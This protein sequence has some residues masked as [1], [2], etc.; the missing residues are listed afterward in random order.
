MS[1]FFNQFV[2][3]FMLVP[4]MAALIVLSF[5][6]PK[7]FLSEEM[8]AFLFMLTT[9]IIGIV[10]ARPGLLTPIRKKTPPKGPAVV[11]LPGPQIVRLRGTPQPGAP[12]YGRPV[13]LPVAGALAE[14]PAVKR[15]KALEAEAAERA[16]ARKPKVVKARRP[17]SL[18]EQAED[19]SPN[20]G[21]IWGLVILIP[22]FFFMT[23]IFAQLPVDQGNLPMNFYGVAILGSI[24]LGVAWAAVVPSAKQRKAE[25]ILRQ[26]EREKQTLAKKAAREK[27]QAQKDTITK[28][29][30]LE[31]QAKER[32]AKQTLAITQA[33]QAAAAAGVAGVS[34]AGGVAGAVGAAGAADA[35]TL[36][37]AEMGAGMV[38]I[39][40]GESLEEI[41]NRL[42]PKKPKIPLEMLSTAN[43]YDDKVALIRFLVS[44]DSGRV[45]KAFQ[46]MIK[47][48]N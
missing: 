17:K 15:A 8:V 13:T 48:G 14:H 39:G 31:A 18:A 9:I 41:K 30:L 24:L 16:A 28:L 45:M 19:Q 1:F 44:E 32:A 33:Q 38:E 40:E 43:S 27:E 20:M 10:I 6:A 3:I 36:S 7:V 37:E 11:V 5:L 22:A 35:T 4:L 46:R 34:T 42:K 2:V 23:F 12:D 26:R 25:R 21:A 29:K 47:P